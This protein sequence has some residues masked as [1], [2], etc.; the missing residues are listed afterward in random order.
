VY[1]K[2]LDRRERVG[3]STPGVW[4]N[5]RRITGL[6]GRS[7]EII[8]REIAK[9]AFGWPTL[10][11]D[12]RSKQNGVF[13]QALLNRKTMR[14]PA[15]ANSNESRE[16]KRKKALVSELD[17]IVQAIVEK[18]KPQRII[19]FG[20]F[21]RGKISETSDID[22]LIVRDTKDRWLDRIKEVALIAR[23]QMAVDFFVLTPKEWR[24]KKETDPFFKEEVFAKGKTIYERV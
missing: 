1:L 3:E 13:G 22:L 16:L 5:P 4:A 15:E 12:G 21:A 23:P 8:S 7:R 20:S 10:L 19:L 2:G 18:L 6:L 11:N 14:Q 9:E 17:R 24:E